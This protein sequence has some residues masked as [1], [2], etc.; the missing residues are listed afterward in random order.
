M[1]QNQNIQQ[2]SK[3]IKI[4]K[5]VFINSHDG[6]PNASTSDNVPKFQDTSTMRCGH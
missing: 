4:N 2:I 3:K 6:E 1:S 5:F